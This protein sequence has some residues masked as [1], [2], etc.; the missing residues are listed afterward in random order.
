MSHSDEVLTVIDRSTDNEYMRDML[1][2]RCAC[3]LRRAPRPPLWD[4][5]DHASIDK[6]LALPPKK[7]G[8][9]D[10]CLCRDHGDRFTRS[11]PRNELRARDL[12]MITLPSTLK[13]VDQQHG[14]RSAGLI[15]REHA[16]P[17]GERHCWSAR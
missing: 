10:P 9:A 6:C 3:V 11:Q 5:V 12:P 7:R 1:A 2:Q 13:T 16:T 14:Y 15:Q 8:L 17:A 4:A